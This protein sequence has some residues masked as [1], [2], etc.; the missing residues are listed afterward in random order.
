[1][2]GTKA[3][4]SSGG[5]SFMNSDIADLPDADDDDDAADAEDDDSF[6][7]GD[8]F[9]GDGDDEADDSADIDAIDNATDDI[10]SD[11]DAAADGDADAD[12]T[13]DS[14]VDFSKI[15]YP[16]HA[17][18]CNK[19]SV[20]F[21]QSFTKQQYEAIFKDFAALIDSQDEEMKRT[22]AGCWVRLAGHD[23]MDF[24]RGEDGEST[25]GSDGCINF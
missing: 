17:L 1:M 10:T 7:G 23:F 22:S 4:F 14:G 13:D 5:G 25:G 15:L 2:A 21:T 12:D 8:A 19:E 11:G 16:S 3:K 18:T 24:R 20:Q 9:G 6:P